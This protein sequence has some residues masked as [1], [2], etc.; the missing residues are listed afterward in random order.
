MKIS[1]NKN[2]EKKFFFNKKRINFDFWLY[3]YKELSIS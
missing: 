1:S 2:E 3:F